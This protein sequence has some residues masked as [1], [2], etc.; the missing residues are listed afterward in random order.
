MSEFVTVL[1]SHTVCHDEGVCNKNCTH[2]QAQHPARG[3]GYQCE[4]FDAR[5]DDRNRLPQCVAAEQLAKEV[6]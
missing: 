3:G 1:V 5:V 4:L 6:L 2:L